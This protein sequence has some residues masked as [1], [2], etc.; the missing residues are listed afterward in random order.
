MYEDNKWYGHRYILLKY[1]NIEKDQRIFAQIQHGWFG[2]IPN[3]WVDKNKSFLNSIVPTL[4]WN[5]KYK[6]KKIIPIGSPFLYLDKILPKK[7]IYSNGTLFIPSHSRSSSEKIQNNK[8]NDIKDPIILDD[9]GIP[10]LYKINLN[11]EFFVKK[12]EKK[13]KP[14][15]TVCFH[16]ADYTR[17]N[18]EFFKRKKWHVV[19]VVSRNN[20][21][22]LMDLRKL[23]LKNEQIVFSDFTSSALIY[24]M[25]LKKKIKI[26]KH[27][28]DWLVKKIERLN[29]KI[30]KNYQNIEIAYNI[31]K[32]EL[33]YDFIKS[34]SELR[35]ILD[36]NNPIK[37]IISYTV[38]FYRDLKYK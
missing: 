15:Y 37:K 23:L 13:F 18:I 31:S 29:K 26:L 5:K 20:N 25:Y 9:K 16:P 22:S 21:F 30:F 24:S 17:E 14:P 27:K 6:N 36:L 19:A 3:P 28:N 10:R 33:G 4:S 2:N 38:G 7:K 34:K 35:K 8:I 32:K 1:L 11:F 12:I